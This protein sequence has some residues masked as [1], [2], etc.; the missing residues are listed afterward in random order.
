M[1]WMKR[2]IERFRGPSGRLRL[3][4][5]L[6]GA[7]LSV[8]AGYIALYRLGGSLVNFSYD[9]PFL[10]HQGKAHENIAIVYVDEMDGGSLDRRNHS[11]LID[12]LGK[13][14]VKA[15]VYDIVFDRPSQDPSVDEEFAAAL[16][17]FRGVDAEGNAI[18]EAHRGV[19]MLACGRENLYY[20][21]AAGEKLLPPIDLLLDAV[22]GFGLVTVEHDSRF[23][24]RSLTT[25]TR[26][27]PSVTW[28]M[29]VALGV[30]LKEEERGKDRWINYAGP[31]VSRGSKSPGSELSGSSDSDLT[32]AIPAFGQQ[33]VI[34][35]EM[36]G[37]GKNSIVVIGGRPGIAGWA[38]GT[39]LFATPFHLLDRSGRM[40]LMSGV[41]LQANL[42]SNLLRRDWL[43]RSSARFETL[44]IVVAGLAAGLLFS[45][46]RPELSPVVA[47]VVIVLL[48]ISGAL[49]AHFDGWWFPWAVVGL[50]QVPV[51]LVWGT[52]SNYCVEFFL[53]R[54]GDVRQEKLE[55]TLSKYLSPEM[56]K[57]LEK[58]DYHIDLGGEVASVAMLVTD[59]ESYSG[60]C[61]AVEDPQGVVTTMNDYLSRTTGHVFNHKGVI[62]QFTGDSIFAAWGTPLAPMDDRES[63]ENAV[64]AAWELCKT[65]GLSVEGSNLRTRFGLHFG[66][67]V[68]GNIGNDH[69]V[70]YSLVG[71]AVNL[72][73][74][75]EGLN[76]MLETTI[77]LSGE[78]REQL[79]GSF[80][81]RRVGRFLVKGRRNPTE[82]HELLGPVVKATEPE[83]ITLYH[84]ALASLEAGDR[85]AA[86]ATFT[87]AD[88]QRGPGG[89]G[90]SR[91]FLK[92]L[93]DN[94]PLAGG[95]V[96]LQEK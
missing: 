51:A 55:T 13:K 14:G 42:L 56:S 81:T 49:T 68:A 63:V 66:Q 17:R 72:A 21:G 32:P 85:E 44:L 18:P 80:R 25:G 41:E 27:E 43:T 67:V 26:D 74:R 22:D 54:R 35:G 11:R 57:Q 93:H 61:E 59:L 79:N 16:R 19:V 58:K 71:D 95:V 15:V 47:V 38:A 23:V 34:D 46:I 8:I 83:W 40:P 82:I 86:K 9:I 77:L 60:M 53:R 94:D 65:A 69:H 36:T 29:A 4:A 3:A 50:A 24:A 96:V 1:N 87:A 75:L 52:T 20:T 6:V 76:K 7:L 84:Q 37:L 45:S 64:S 2:M 31:P 5:A 39:D 70:A 12:A 92:R 91:F 88:R 30:P 89:D 62:I 48:A 10:V 78:T 90:P 33:S 73:H 28:N